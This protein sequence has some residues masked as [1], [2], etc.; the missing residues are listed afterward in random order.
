MAS[1]VMRRDGNLG[2]CSVSMTVRLR[3]VSNM[4]RKPLVREG[5][6]TAGPRFS[7]D[8]ISGFT[9]GGRSDT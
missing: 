7:T 8:S 1:P 3:M 4:F 2:R 6:I 5:A 9:C